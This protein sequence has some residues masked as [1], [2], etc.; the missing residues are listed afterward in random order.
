MIEHKHSVDG[1]QVSINVVEHEEDLE[2][3]RDFIRGN[4]RFLGL[5]S[6][7][8]GLDTYSDSFR[9]RL[10]Q[11]GTPTEAW[12]V[13]VEH[14]GRFVEDV[15]L[16][17]RGV[18]GFVLHNASY[19][20]QVFEQT[21]GV[22][23]EDMWPKVHDTKIYAHLVDPL[24]QKDGGIGHSLEALTRRHVDEYVADN[25]KGLMK[26]LRE[27]HKTTNA[28]IWKK[29]PLSDPNYQLY[30]GMDPILAA[31]LL[32]KL[33][34]LVPSV[35]HSLVAYEH[36]LAEI[37]SYMD[38]TGLLLDVDY[39]TELAGKLRY[40]ESQQNEL[41]LTFGCDN[42]N[43]PVGCSGGPRAVGLQGQRSNSVW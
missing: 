7:T 36:K 21:L 32:R 4:L 20:L 9:C 31:R 34:P 10:V 42:L 14:G 30:S 26:V 29:V 38:R 19:D 1:E 2:G 24:G 41:A 40:E 16:A 37:C 33:I 5:D 43:A 27:E 25:V 6:E 3:F 17:L 8:T 18:E 15:R 39:S 22:P 28:N 13:P 23:M 35:T 12:V 11:F